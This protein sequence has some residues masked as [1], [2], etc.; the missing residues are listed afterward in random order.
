MTELISQEDVLIADHSDNTPKVT[1]PVHQ[2]YPWRQLC[3]RVRL[4][5]KKTDRL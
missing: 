5:H 1:S 3:F 2:Q 4:T